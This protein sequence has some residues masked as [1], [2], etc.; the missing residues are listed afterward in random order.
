MNDFVLC[1]FC[2]NCGMSMIMTHQGIA[3]HEWSADT[4]RCGPGK[5]IPHLSAKQI[6]I[7]YQ[8]KL[9]E[10]YFETKLN[11]LAPKTI[12]DMMASFL[13]DEPFLVAKILK[14]AKE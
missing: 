2:E 12:E 11:L 1:G 7:I 9:Y 13:E 14:E 10:K 5:F 4:P 3:V 8:S 6:R